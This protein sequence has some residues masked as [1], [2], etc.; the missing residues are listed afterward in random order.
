MLV[1]AI[2]LALAAASV[3]GGDRAAVACGGLFCQNDP[4]DQVG[5]RIVFAVNDDQTVTSLIEI[6]YMGS[7][8]D[9]SW[10]LPIPTAIEAEDLAVP[11]EGEGVFDELHALTDVRIIAPPRPPCTE[12]IDFGFS[13]EDDS[14]T[15]SADSE[16]GVE[17]FASGE[18][19]PFGF[20]VIG[21][22]DPGALIRW[23]RDNNYRVEQQ[24]EPLI[25][26]Y[27][28]E[29]FAFVAMRLLD[30]E[31]A[32]SIMPIEITY[33]GDKPMIPLRLT[34]VAAADE[35]PVFT[36]IFADEQ[37]VPENYEH[38]E[39][40]T[41]ELTFSDFGGN[42]YRSLVQRR[43]DALDGRAFITEFAGP[44]NSIELSHP[45]LQNMGRQHGYLTRLSTFI[46]PDEMTVD[47]VFAFDGDRAD[48]SNVRDAS[49]L[50]GLYRCEREGSG[51]SLTSDAISPISSDGEV[52]AFTPTSTLGGNGTGILAVLAAVVLA[53]IGGAVWLIKRGT[54]QQPRQT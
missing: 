17:V 28:Q 12:P 39:I 27:V 10:V 9:F 50:T 29:E 41:A 34:A 35:M 4:V 18:V 49:E 8:E 14:A 15:A 46:S 32:E 33:G 42:D 54:T 25:D 1:L 16:E 53:A 2:G 31:D 45:Y 38:M 20:D 48:V 37:A 47:P 36:W 23:L 51:F 24:M 3:L 11:D 40:A 19:G 22:A 26:V 21:S 6:Q 30:G 44:S 7:A 13:G 52:L 43:A 5:E